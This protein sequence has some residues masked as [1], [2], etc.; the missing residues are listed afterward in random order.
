MEFKD[1]NG[2]EISCSVSEYLELTKPTKN[3]CFFAKTR[4]RKPKTIDNGC[5]KRMKWIHKRT[6]Q[7]QAE[8]P[9]MSYNKVYR[10]AIFEW[11]LRKN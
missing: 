7:L 10:K 11:S 2:N 3:D 9:Y 4:V 1:K 6:K 5:A 8:H